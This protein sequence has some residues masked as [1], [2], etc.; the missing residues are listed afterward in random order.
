MQTARMPGHARYVHTEQAECKQSFSVEKTGK[1]VS[2]EAQHLHG[3]A[4]GRVVEVCCSIV[5]DVRWKKRFLVVVDLWE[6]AVG[7]DL[8]RSAED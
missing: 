8:R 2:Q 1:G 4:G 7:A 3:M 5:A 6:V